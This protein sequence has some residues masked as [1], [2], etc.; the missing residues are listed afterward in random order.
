MASA[1]MAVSE[2][3]VMNPRLIAP[4]IGKSCTG[5]FGKR[6][7]SMENLVNCNLTSIF[8]Y[9]RLLQRFRHGEMAKG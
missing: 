6:L 1:E 8:N 7:N 4:L 3:L 2:D 9:L 5:Y